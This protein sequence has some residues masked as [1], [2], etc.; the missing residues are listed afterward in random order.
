MSVTEKLLK[1]EQNITVKDE[2]SKYST[3]TY[4]KQHATLGRVINPT[5]GQPCKSSSRLDDAKAGCLIK[6]LA[7]KAGLNV[8]VAE[9]EKA[10]LEES[11]MLDTWVGNVGGEEK[12][13]SGSQVKALLDDGTSGGTEVVPTAFDSNV[14]TFPLLTGELFPRVQNVELSS[15]RQVE[16]ASF[17]NITTEWGVADDSNISLFTTTSMI[18]NITTTIQNITVAIEMGRDFLNDAAVDVGAI[19]TGLIGEKLQAELD[20]VIAVGASGSSEPIGLTN[21]SGLNAVSSVNGSSGPWR[22]TD[23]SNLLFGVGKQYRNVANCSFISND[24]TFN[25]SRAIA[26]G[27]GDARPLMSGG[28]VGA[29]YGLYR[30]L[31]YNHAVQNN[32]P[33]GTAIF[34]NLMKYRMYRRQGLELR[35]IDGGT[36]L[37]RKNKVLLIARARYGGQVMDGNAF[38]IITDGAS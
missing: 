31:G 23:Y 8:Q 32:V 38:A 3:A 34:G 12:V 26:V 10:L 28:D 14:V 22:L 25:R 9:H 30:T 24:T 20:R 18:A 15:G 35:F 19:V 1:S 21:A 27:S 5:T 37:A 16:T 36:T 11:A 2:S 17:E 6:S 7:S 33:N 13:F 29:G 4:E